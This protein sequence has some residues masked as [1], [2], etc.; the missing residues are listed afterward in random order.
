MRALIVLALGLSLTLGLTAPAAFA[1]SGKDLKPGDWPR[2]ARD[3]GGTHYSP[4][5]QITPANVSKLAT[6]CSTCPSAMRWWPWTGR[7]ARSCGAIP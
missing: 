3:L 2:Y 7:A 5:S 4:L 6:A 1:Q